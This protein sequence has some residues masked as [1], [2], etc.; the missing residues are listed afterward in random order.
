VPL[1]GSH[2]SVAG[3]FTKAVD[4]ALKLGCET[5]QIFTKAP[6]QWYGREISDSEAI[7]F[8]SALRKGK[9]KLP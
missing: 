3:G 4:A 1:F 7:K 2:L 8:R 5:V 6:S 9:L